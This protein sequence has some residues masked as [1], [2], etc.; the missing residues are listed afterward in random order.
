MKKFTIV[1]ILLAACAM[2]MAA[3]DDMDA[4]SPDPAVVDGSRQEITQLTRELNQ[5]AVK[6]DAG[7]YQRLLAENYTAI[8]ESGQLQTKQMVVDATRRHAVKFTTINTSSI[9]VQ[10]TGDKAVETDVS[11]VAGTVKHRPFSG[12]YGSKRV[13]EKRDGQW[14]VVSLTVY[15]AK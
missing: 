4:A 8:N 9:E 10:V 1:L 7:V 11:N 13:W 15:Q 3:K 12:T 14:Q 5:A 6:E 2:T